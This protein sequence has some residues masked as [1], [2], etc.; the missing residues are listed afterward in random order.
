M[1]PPTPEQQDA[2]LAA[3]TGTVSEQK[4]DSD[5][6]RDLL[7]LELVRRATNNG[8][9]WSAIGRALG[10]SGKEAKRQMKQLARHTQRQV[11]LAKQDR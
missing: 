6:D 8:V 7:R 2:A 4:P 3:L 1:S 5:L 10:C 11:L 9:P